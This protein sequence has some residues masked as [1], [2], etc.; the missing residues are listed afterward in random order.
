MSRIYVCRLSR[1]A[2]RKL[3]FYAI[4][5]AIERG[6]CMKTLVVFYSLEGNS[7]FIAGVI[8]KKLQAD[9][10]KL[11]TVKPFPT[12]GGGK[13][14]KGG[15]SVVFKLRPKLAN[16]NIDMSQYDNVVIGTPV[17]AGGFSSPINTFVSKYKFT[18]KKIALFL[19]SAGPD[20][21]KCFAKL[22][23]AL[24]ENDFVG[25]IDFIEPLKKDKEE[26]VKT[27]EQWAEGLKF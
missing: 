16:K 17:W 20:V 8:G 27:A 23:K 21:E 12:Q 5:G 2:N 14:F 11:E 9:V 25:E 10:V 3:V 4:V 15:M 6:K 22:K 13:F 24:G 19:T 1:N 7:E 18:G 26:V